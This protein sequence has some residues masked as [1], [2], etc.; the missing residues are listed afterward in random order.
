M[1]TDPQLRTTLSNPAVSLRLYG[2]VVDQETSEVVTYDPT[3]IARNL[4]QTIVS[5]LSDPPLTADSHMRWLTCLGY[6]QAGKS[7]CAATS[8]YPLVAYNEGWD[9][10]LIADKK[11][12]AQ[13]LFDRVMFLHNHWSPEVRTKQI[14]TNETRSL[15]L[16]NGSK[17]RVLSGESDA[18]GI[19]QSVDVFIGSELPYWANASRQFSL[20]YPAMINRKRSRMLLESTPAP[21]SEPSAQWWMDK[22]RDAQMGRGRDLFAFFPFWDGFLN[23]RAWPVGQPL[24]HEEIRLMELYGPQGLAHENLAFRRHV[25]DS[26][27]EI[28]RNPDLFGVYYPF[29]PITCWISSG[30]GMIPASAVERFRLLMP[31]SDGLTIFKEPSAG[32]QYLIG[33]DPSGW[34]RDHAAFQVLEVWDDSWEQVA[35]FGANVDPNDFAEILEQTG[36]KYNM[37]RIG[38]ERNGVGAAP[39]V[40]LRQSKYP[41]L[42]YDQ[43]YKPGVHKS[44]HD[45]WVTLLVDALLDKLLLHGDDTVAQI[46][47][48]RGDK[49][50][51]RTIRSE[52]LSTNAGRRRARHHWDKASALMVACAIAPYMPVR[53]RPK[54]K[55]DNVVMFR[56]MTWNQLKDYEKVCKAAKATPGGRRRA[57]YTSRRKR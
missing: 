18:V 43:A 57:H 14:S 27:P 6:R 54:P 53:Y 1:I 21:L 41:N 38:V 55:P 50:V 56:D 9:A 40:L 36:V 45:E 2:K 30:A 34:G 24:S 20:I 8:V 31:E 19:G 5:Y 44:N 35:S 22:C 32:A 7:T 28:R 39:I 10:V 3:R 52:L 42:H 13:Y 26:D 25:M 47:G 29:D 46:R 11:D 33:V 23:R 48:Y 17:Y 12:R 16:E 4:Q 37:A 51:E 49:T 15:T